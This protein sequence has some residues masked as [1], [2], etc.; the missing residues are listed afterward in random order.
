M[1]PSMSVAFA[2][3]TSGGVRVP[4][5]RRRFAGGLWQC[6]LALL[7]P[8]AAVAETPEDLFEK[9]VR[10]LLLSKCTKCHS[11]EKSESGLKLTSRQGLMTG[12]D[13]GPAIV[14]GEA[15]K[16]MLVSVIKPG[17]DF[18]M[19][20]DGPLTGEEV[21]AVEQWIDSGAAWPGDAI[22]G[23]P[24]KTR[25]GEPTDEERRHWA[26]QPPVDPPVPQMPSAAGAA[27]HPIDAFIQAKLAEK[28]IA[29]VG[30]ADKRTLLRR[31]TYDLTGLPPAPADLDSF[32]GD[33]SSDAFT[34]VVERLLASPAYGERWGR[35]W[36]DLVRYAD[37]AGETGDYPAMLA[38]KYRNYVI[39]AFNADKPYDRFLREQIAGDLVADPSDPAAF[40]EAITA[41]GFLAIARRFGFDTVS[42]MH[43]TYQDMIDTVGQ[44][45]IGLTVGCARCHDH[46]YDAITAADY[47]ALY[48]IFES[49]K[50]SFPGDE[51]TK[52][53]RDMVPLLPPDQLAGP[54]RAFETRLA[55]TERLLNEAEAEKK[56]VDELKKQ[57]ESLKFAPPFPTAYGAVE[58]TPK[59]T[60]I[61]K[62]G[63][64]KRPGDEVP[65]RF[66]AV[67][68]G[69]PVPA[70][71]KGSGRRQLADWI[72]SPANPLTARVIVNRVWQHHFGEGLVATENDFG[73]R[74]AAPTHPE[75]LDWLACRFVENGWSIKWLHR[76]I[77][78]SETYRLASTFDAAAA[79]ADPDDTLLWR[80]RRRRLSAEEMR[81]SLLVLGG[82]LDQTPGEGHPFP[83]VTDWGFSQHNPFAGIYDTPKRSVYLMTPRLGRHPLLALF[84]GADANASTPHR[85]A[86]TVP[87]QALFWMNAPLV[88]EQ[89]L[90][91][92]ARLLVEPNP[93]ARTTLAYREAFGR[94]PTDAEQAEAADFVARYRAA[95]DS[96]DIPAA[97]RDRQAWAG[98][99]RTMFAA[100][101]FLHVD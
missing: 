3:S 96:T 9:H 41:T 83:P 87:T 35:H 52:R 7:L 84:D 68:G 57:H 51:Q 67:L 14:P 99:A 40:A 23:G 28:G 13:S 61:Q 86:T 4:N 91:F 50:L 19:P 45:T 74:G 65:R 42:H 32:E 24:R 69:E 49:T 58:G 34:N 56:G 54:R 53:P 46:K 1:P 100:N 16:S 15:A 39:A 60:K 101:E 30:P 21:A 2:G 73:V 63:E 36:L 95:L 5:L 88:H 6:M 20:P 31:V 10:P 17:G 70:E 27:V 12:G 97:D 93:T 92:A 75:L 62:R 76:L 72:A 8:A 18:E 71:E 33:A 43:L 81:D 25:T 38:W 90:A 80:F 85:V 26:Y 48:G 89:S 98:F 66:L 37:T 59:N 78:S 79:A 29:Q 64:P 77:L 11:D 44:A 47:Y 94:R 82:T 55:V 22:G